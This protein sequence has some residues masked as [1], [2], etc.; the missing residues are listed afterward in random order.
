[1]VAEALVTLYSTSAVYTIWA[2]SFWFKCMFLKHLPCEK[3]R[4]SH[5]PLNADSLGYVAIYHGHHA[6]RGYFQT[7]NRRY[8][9]PKKFI[10]NSYDIV[11]WGAEDET[12]S[13]M[14]EL[15]GRILQFLV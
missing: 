3:R 4:P 10:A 5:G 7:L 1:M 15:V 11:R 13:Y 6:V 8:N 12:I 2:D 14:L 9:L